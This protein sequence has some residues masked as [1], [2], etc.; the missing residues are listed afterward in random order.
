M[1][2]TKIIAFGDSV[3]AGTSA[4]LD[5]FRDCFQ[6]GTKTVNTVRETQTWRSIT[7]RILSDHIEDEVEIINSGVAGDN[8]L[9]GLARLEQDV[10]SHAPDYVLVMFGAEDVLQCMETEAFHESLEK[11][12][13]G[14]AARD[15][16]P[17]LITPAPISE[18]MT[19]GDCTI[20]ELRQRQERLSALVQTVRSLAEEKSLPLLD[21]NRYFLGNRLAYDHLFE[22]WLPDGVA[23]AGMASFFAG[24]LLP[25]L[26]VND[27]PGPILCGY[28]KGYRDT[29]GDP[30]WKHNAFTDITFFDGQFYLAFRNGAGH[31]PPPPP[32]GRVMVLKSGDGILWEREAILHVS[33]VAHQADPK[34]LCADGRLFVYVPTTGSMET[35][36]AKH[37][38][39]GYERLGPG[40]WS[41]PFECAPCVFWRPK[42]WRDQYVVAPYG[43]SEKDAAVKLLSS[44][45]GRSWKVISDILPFDTGGNE[46]DLLVEGDKLVAF[47]R[48][49]EGSNHE[50][51]I[52][53]YI[54]SENRWETVSS[55]RN[56]QA[57][58]VFKA[59]NRTMIIGRYC[60]QSDEGFRELRRDWNAFNYGTESESVQVDSSR[61]EAYHHGLRTG[62]FL[63]DGTRPRLVMEFLSAG[64]SSYPGVVQYGNEYVISDY[65]MHEYYPTIRRPGDWNTPNDIYVSRIRFEG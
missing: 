10:L 5:V 25:M 2:R 61:V 21:L 24:E 46:T 8:S 40:N 18:R 4:K 45:N 13:N 60:S 56:I 14:I 53:T 47:S 32:S 36:P 17:V 34:L 12:V 31:C 44:K 54:P 42:K 19:A 51:Q 63:M 7:A 64:D 37:T 43:W 59:G 57:P 20:Y 6:Y 15:I 58:C 30:D 23:Q 55:G 3:T 26:G 41:E 39:Y 29:S 50:M 16:R 62:L 35:R 38:T 49:G 65:S 28:R 1:S 33:G 9:K 27:F 22:G 52:S 48:T 11:I